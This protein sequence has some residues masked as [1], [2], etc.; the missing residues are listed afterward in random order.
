MAYA[1]IDSTFATGGAGADVTTGA[2]DTTGATLL[3]LGF[4]AFQ[5]AVV[6]ASDSKGNTW[7]PLFAD[8]T[9]DC[10]VGVFYVNSA[11]PTVGSGH[12]F[13][14]A[15]GNFTSVIPMVF[16]GS[17]ATPADN[18][19][20]DT[21]ASATSLQP[22]SLSPAE[23]NELFIALGLSLS[24]TMQAISGYTTMEN[25]GF[26]IASYKIQTSGSAENP[27]FTSTGAERLRVTLSAWKSDFIGNPWF[28]Y[29]QQ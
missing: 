19:T 7:T 6:T 17:A 24:G 1:F 27:T 10:A 16:S 18:D 22:G 23:N 26:A 11:T 8:V 14:I 9:N 2:I 5:D 29:A 25:D 13:T 21:S 15:A 3:L 12:T 4:T 28:A 20:A